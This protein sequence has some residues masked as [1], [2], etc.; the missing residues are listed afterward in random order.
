MAQELST[1][2]NPHSELCLL[3]NYSSIFEF[4][5][6]ALGCSKSQAKKYLSKKI[7][8]KLPKLTAQT[9][10][11]LPLDLLNWDKISPTYH[12]EKIRIIADDEDF[13]VIHKP[14]G[15]HG[16]PS[17][18]GDKYNVM[19]FLR[20]QGRREQNVNS[21]DRERSLL[22]R[23]DRDTSGVLVLVKS[24]S[25]LHKMRENFKEYILEKKYLAIVSGNFDVKGMCE[26]FL[27]PYGPRGQIMKA[28]SPQD[29]K[30]KEA[31]MEVECL[32]YNPQKDVSLVQIH[33]KTGLRHQIRCQLQTL[34]FP[35]LG[36]RTYGGED[37]R[38]MYLHCFEYVLFASNG[39]RFYQSKDAEL[40]GD[41]FDLDAIL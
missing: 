25:L 15:V 13:L 8:K 41:F 11:S 17:S 21:C 24:E 33:L 18:Y 35:I 20:S 2:N 7:E 10:I 36:D 30:A 28:T 23:L 27:K 6:E 34:G 19:A 29:P 9:R 37:E 26:H 3:Q 4:C 14:P 1:E 31:L 5:Q 12:G 39:E 40:F 16:H 32:C 22:Y 38:R